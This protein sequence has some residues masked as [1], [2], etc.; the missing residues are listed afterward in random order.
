MIDLQWMFIILVSIL[1]PYRITRDKAKDT[2]LIKA[3]AWKLK[4]SETGFVFELNIVLWLQTIWD[5][6]I[7]VK[8]KEK[9]NR[10]TV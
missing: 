9:L 1:I 6:F 5:H 8:A 10:T 4:I 2:F 3:L 7:E